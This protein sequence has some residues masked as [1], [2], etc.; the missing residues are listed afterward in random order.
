MQA[1]KGVVRLQGVKK[2]HILQNLPN[3][4]GAHT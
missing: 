1:D 4:A 2:I 3:Y